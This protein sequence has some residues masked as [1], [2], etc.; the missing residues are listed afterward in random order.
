MTALFKNFLLVIL[1]DMASP[2]FLV[3]P[4]LCWKKS[5]G[6]TKIRDELSDYS[7]FVNLKRGDFLKQRIGG[8]RA[9]ER[10]GRSKMLMDHRRLTTVH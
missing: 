2:S 9:K 5:I 1:L 4:H 3:Y 8:Q 10:G 6:R 7:N